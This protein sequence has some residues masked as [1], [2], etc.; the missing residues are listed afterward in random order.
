M[1]VPFYTCSSN[2]DTC[3]AEPPH[4]EGDD[5][6]PEA[7]EEERKAI[8]SIRNTLGVFNTIAQPYDFLLTCTVRTPPKHSIGPFVIAE[9]PS[10]HVLFC[11]TLLFL[12]I[13]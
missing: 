12:C 10:E 2:G 1:L 6:V 3:R 7:D 8:F 9:K 4:E 5:D 13:L 11:N